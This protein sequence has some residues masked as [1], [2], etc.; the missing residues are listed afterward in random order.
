MGFYLYRLFLY[1]FR[2]LLALE[3]DLEFIRHLLTEVRYSTAAVTELILCPFI[4]AGPNQFFTIYFLSVW[5]A[6]V[7]FVE[8]DFEI[9]HLVVKDSTICWLRTLHHLKMVLAD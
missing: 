8:V 7:L 9:Q 5:L 4:V 6:L 3:L 1:C 2:Y